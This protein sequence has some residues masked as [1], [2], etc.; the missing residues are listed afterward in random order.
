MAEAVEGVSGAFAASSG[1]GGG[2]PGIESSP[3]CMTKAIWTMEQDEPD[4][5]D[6]MTLQ[7]IHLFQQDQDDGY[8]LGHW[9]LPSRL[10]FGAPTHNYATL[11]VQ[12]PP[13]SV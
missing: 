5:D 7:A 8:L 12:C 6:D 2:A 3:R 1:S 9:H 13:F 11:P 10:C 4:I